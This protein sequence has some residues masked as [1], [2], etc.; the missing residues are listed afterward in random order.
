MQPHATPEYSTWRIPRLVLFAP[1][2]I[3]VL[4]ARPALAAEALPYGQ[5][6]FWKVEK[7]GAAPSYVLGTMHVTDDRVVNLPAPVEEAFNAADSATFE[8]LKTDGV[9]MR[10]A[11]AMILTDGR[12]LDAILGPALSRPRGER[13]GRYGLP[14]DGVKHLRPWALT[15]ML[16]VPQQEVGRLAAGDLALDDWLQDEAERQGK[17]LHQL[18]TIDDQIAVFSSLSEADQVTLLRVAID[19]NAQI[20]AW[21]EKL[22]GHYLA[23]DVSAIHALMIEQTAGMNPELAA[24]FQASFIDARNERMVARMAPRLAEGNAFIAVG[25][26]HLPGERGILRLL[27]RQGY[28]VERVY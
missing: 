2:L 9:Q 17:A 20:D 23:R 12:S 1:L 26:L 3:L 13:A 10:L 27:D 22:L 28:R 7:P 16:S 24:T 8:V 4:V 15:I 14:A 19:Q 11:R 18:E 6:V 21:F 5:G 25:A